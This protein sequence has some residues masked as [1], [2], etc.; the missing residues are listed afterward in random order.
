MGAPGAIRLIFLAV[1]V[2]LVDLLSGVF[3]R[4]AIRKSSYFFLFF[5]FLFFRHFIKYYSWPCGYNICYC[6]MHAIANNHMKIYKS[7]F[8]FIQVE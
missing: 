2:L 6:I 8:N 7:I 4:T 3:F 5:F 1:M